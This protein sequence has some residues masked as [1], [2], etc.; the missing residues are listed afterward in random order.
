M[1]AQTLANKFLE[2]NRLANFGN[3]LTR[4]HVQGFRCHTST[5]IDFISPITAFCGRNGT[6]KSTLIQLAAAAYASPA[7]ETPT[8]YIRDFLVRGTLD[9]DP[10]T[11][12]ASVEYQYWDGER[13][14]PGLGP[15]YVTRQTTVS[16]TAARWSGYPRRPE[17]NVFF[18]GVG[19]YLPASE[20]RDFIFR[21]AGRLELRTTETATAVTKSWTSRVLG[22][23]YDT[24]SR[25]TVAVSDREGSLLSVT[26]HGVSYSEAHMGH[27]E[28]RTQYL[29]AA[30]ELL[31]EK[32]LVLIEEPETS[33]H[34]AA[35]YEL[36]AYLIDVAKRRGHQIVL[37]THSEYLLEALP[38]AS[39]IYLH[40]EGISVRPIPG[41]ASREALS[42]MSDGHVPALWVLVEDRC[43]QI[44]LQE[45]VRRFD[46]GFLSTIAVRVSG[47]AQMI[48]S[49]APVV[50]A[51][52][53]VPMVAVRDGDQAEDP[54]KGLFKLPG[55]GPPEKA[56]FECLE[57]EEHI[58][59][60]YH[61]E[62][63]D[64]RAVAPADHHAWPGECARQTGISIEALLTEASQVYAWTVDEIEG[65]RL[66]ELLRESIP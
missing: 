19:L 7:E 52:K 22:S 55:T 26:R 61:V 3:C 13:S 21:N 11:P 64:V 37:T 9:P 5:V 48:G 8:Y 23:A 34:A 10:F 14:S 43:G 38:S 6:G 36:A 2:A 58:R 24:M 49:I 35:Q 4:M 18:V 54:G 50:N 62:M 42:M 39:R 59:S 66:V 30:L 33:L 20:R 45:I 25:N 53:G 28:G 12:T 56:L 29:I 63:A 47:G 41:L 40:R 44:V 46:Q 17:R 51:I 1:T 65:N 31:P 27:G 32:T 15:R 57:V 60:K 16:R